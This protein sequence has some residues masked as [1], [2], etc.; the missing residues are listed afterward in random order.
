MTEKWLTLLRYFISMKQQ[1]LKEEV[2]M[3]TRFNKCVIVW[4]YFLTILQ[5]YNQFSVLICGGMELFYA[6]S[7]ESFD[8]Y[9]AFELYIVDSVLNFL[10]AITL[11]YLFYY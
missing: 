6:D 8:F 2:L 9:F 1:K 10:T 3:F 4:V 7:P 11:L 5:V